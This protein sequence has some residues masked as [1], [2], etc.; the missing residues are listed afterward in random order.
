[1][2][3]ASSKSL[4]SI[5]SI[6]LTSLAIFHA[7]RTYII[8]Y[9]PLPHEYW[10]IMGEVV[11]LQPFQPIDPVKGTMGPSTSLHHLKPELCFNWF[12]FGHCW[13]GAFGVGPFRL[14]LLLN[15]GS[16][17][18][19]PPGGDDVGKKDFWMSSPLF[20]VSLLISSY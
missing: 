20:V 16:I 15:Y 18:A 2:L 17:N 9:T 6:P 8:I 11:E 4:H 10:P 12:H 13:S 1:M 7:A 3:E 19:D 14:P 5:F